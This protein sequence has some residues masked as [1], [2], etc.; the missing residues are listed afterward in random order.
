[1]AFEK[2]KEFAEFVSTIPADKFDI[3]RIS[4]CA[5]G[6]AVASGRF[7][8]MEAS[9]ESAAWVLGIPKSVADGFFCGGLKSQ[10]EMSTREITP[11]MVTD[12]INAYILANEPKEDAPVASEAV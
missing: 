7:G 8:R 4:C 9:H 11:Q 12:K 10:Y 5:V 6:H 1:M 3:S 2:L